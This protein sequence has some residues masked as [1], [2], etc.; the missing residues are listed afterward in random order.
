MT[1]FP[2]STRTRVLASSAA[3][4]ALTLGLSACGG[5]DD[6]TGS[7]GGSGA[8]SAAKPKAITVEAKNK[9]CS[10][11]VSELPSG[12][13]TFSIKNSGSDVTEFYVYGDG[14][15]IISEVENIGPAISKK[16][17]VDLDPGAY[18]L[19]CKPGMTGTGV[20]SPLTVTG[21][22]KAPE[23]L[24]QQ[25]ADAVSDYRTYV[26]NQ[27]NAL[28]ALTT[29][30]V[31]AVKAGDLEKAKALYSPARLRY[32]TIEPIAES[33]G[34][35]DPLIDMRE[36]DA[37]GGTAFVGFHKLEQD[38][39]KTK[40]ISSAGPTAVA[41]LANV[42]KLVAELPKVE[43]TPLTMANGAKALLDEVAASKVT[44]EEERYS[45]VDLVDFSGNVEGAKTA[46]TTLRP[47][48]VSRAPELVASLDKRF[49]AL[50]DA[51]DTHA[52][53]KG[54]PGFIPGSGFVSYDAL[55]KQ[56]VRA[57]AVEV[58]AISEPLGAIPAAVSK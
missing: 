34:E 20:R 25:L 47:A 32:E 33:F 17:I 29:P 28:L 9:S 24:D 11:S 16:L 53:T 37:T 43:I 15:K 30:L 27:G 4:A 38:L 5:S 39:W 19:T 52:A 46:Y 58:D 23:P 40:N 49:A 14:D 2:P 44:G 54:E 12:R 8:G 48:L 56:E 50:R 21:A 22:S 51:L 13:H 57:L 18:Q 10:V 41:L 42:K 31:A 35:L 6:A 55:S 3:L 7:P 1:P 45:R 36:D 26:E